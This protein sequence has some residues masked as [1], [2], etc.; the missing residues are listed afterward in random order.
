M[1][2]SFLCVCGHD[3]SYHLDWVNNG[4]CV[5]IAHKLGKLMGDHC[6][7]KEFKLDNLAYVKQ[8]QEERTV[9]RGFGF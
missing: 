5:K 6:F 4:Q 3:R 1:N 7:C 2:S 9:K 8:V